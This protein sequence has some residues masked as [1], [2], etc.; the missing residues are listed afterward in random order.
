V[1]AAVGGIKAALQGQ[2]KIARY[3]GNSL[4]AQVEKVYVELGGKPFQSAEARAASER[5]HA[6]EHGHELAGQ[7]R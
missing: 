5:E 1:K 2:P 3:V 7:G 4:Q 6:R